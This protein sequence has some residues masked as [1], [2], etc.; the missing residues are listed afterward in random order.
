MMVSA[1]AVEKRENAIPFQAG[2]TARTTYGV[3]RDVFQ[4]LECFGVLGLEFVKCRQDPLQSA[5]GK[6]FACAWCEDICAAPG[7]RFF[8]IALA[9]LV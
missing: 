5:F 7:L 6:T 3:I 9:R 8:N 1:A 2:P 4:S